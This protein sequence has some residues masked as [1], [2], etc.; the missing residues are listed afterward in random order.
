MKEIIKTNFNDTSK[1]TWF[2][3]NETSKE[4]YEVGKLKKFLTMSKFFMQDTLLFLTQKSV[5]NFVDAILNFL[6]DK[7]EIIDAFAVKNTFP[8]KDD[9]VED[10]DDPLAVSNDPIP[11]FAV[12]LIHEGTN[13]MP[14]Y[15]LKPIDIVITIM[16]IFDNGLKT[17]QE[18]N[19][20]EQKLLP[21]LFKTNTKMYLKATVRPDMEPE[22]PDPAD[23]KLLPDENAWVWYEYCRLRERLEEAVKPLEDY[24]DC[25]KKFEKEYHLD[26]E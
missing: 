21:H 19:Q 25:Y 26:P 18:I 13:S 2:N 23:L 3:L 14:H 10:E 5:K 15:N 8:R 7:V 1:A 12:D 24:L 16:L 9:L 11:L 20:L 17:L 4:T 22:T 6:P